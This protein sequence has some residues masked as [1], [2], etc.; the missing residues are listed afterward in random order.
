MKEKKEQSKGQLGLISVSAVVAANIMGSGIALLPASFAAIGSVTIISWFLTLIGALSLAYVF[1]R[2]GLIDPE[3]GGPVAYAENLSSILGF[4]TGLLYWL[5]N[6][7]GNLAIAITGVEYSSL[8]YP[9]L[10]DPLIG[11]LATIILVWLF[12]IINFFGANKVAKI[13]SFTVVLL[14]IPVIGTAIFGWIYFSPQQFSDNWIVSDISAS[15]AVFSGILLAIWSF[16]GVESASVSA[17]IVKNPTFTIPAATM[18]G[19]GI[20]AIAYI[21]STTAISGMFPAEEVAH[22]GA[23]FALAFGKIA[24]DWVRP[25]VSLF[26]SI[27]CLA[28]LGSWM[29]IVGQA[30][31]AASK[32]GTLPKIFGKIL[33]KNRIPFP[34]LVINSL[35]MTILMIF[36]MVISY[37]K[38]QTAIESFSQVISIAVLLTLLPYLYSSIFLIKIEGKKVLLSLILGTIAALLCFVAFAGAKE[39]QLVGT[40]IISFVCFIIYALKQGK[41][42]ILKKE[43]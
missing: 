25:I 10:K 12:T 1:S 8:F 32:E 34:A 33:G 41:S 36:L 5:A 17:G 26:T 23:P 29:M 2:L 9:P 4:Q 11:G 39:N 16:I 15:K 20:A 37:V 21:S 42:K 35:L 31:I 18:I 22:S 30:G 40:I 3:P 27:A 7:I 6:W 28:S 19:T 43:D 38:H 14:L 24:G 13:V